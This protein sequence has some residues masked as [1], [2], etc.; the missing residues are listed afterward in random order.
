MKNIFTFLAAALIL[1]SL[2]SCHQRAL[3][4]LESNREK[5]DALNDSDYSFDLDIS[6]FC[7]HSGYTPATVVVQADTVAAILDINT[8]QDLLVPSDSSL[9]FD[10]YGE[11]FPTIDGLFDEIDNAVRGNADKVK[12][13][14]DED[15]GYPMEISI[16]WMK[17][18]VDDESAYT[19]LAVR[20]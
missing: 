17:F 3:N 11:Y 20:L 9:V 7:A 1:T 4:E 18:A 8:G 13:T 2:F 10:V 14:Y 6:C 12:V 19:V 16:D 5:W 15:Q